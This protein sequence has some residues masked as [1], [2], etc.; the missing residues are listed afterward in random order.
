[1]AIR[2]Y[3][4]VLTLNVSGLYAPIRRQSSTSINNKIIQKVV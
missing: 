4:S 3:K 2:S 1:M